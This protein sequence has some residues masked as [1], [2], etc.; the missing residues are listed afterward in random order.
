MSAAN[1]WPCASP[2]TPPPGPAIWS[3]T[4]GD[5]RPGGGSST[6][7]AAAPARWAGG[8]RRGCPGSQHWVVHDRD[9][10]LLDV[11]AA[12]PPGP[13]IDGA[14]ITVETQASDITRLQSG[15]LAGA[16]VIT[17]RRCWTC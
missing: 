17:A 14:A 11:A 7:S 4:S 1:G 5:R 15:E 8:W 12:Q 6:I 10:A 16:S 13:A 9:Q 2:L 3:S